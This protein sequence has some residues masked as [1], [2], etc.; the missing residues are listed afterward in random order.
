MKQ[1][2]RASP[3]QL[4]FVTFTKSEVTYWEKFHCKFRISQFQVKVG[5]KPTIKKKGKGNKESQK[6]L[7][8]GEHLTYAH[9]LKTKMLV[10]YIQL[11]EKYAL[12]VTNLAIPRLIGNFQGVK[13]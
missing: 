7:P 12:G 4:G 11:G 13:I 8:K 1:T 2:R 5:N 3:R 10:H 6:D 9:A